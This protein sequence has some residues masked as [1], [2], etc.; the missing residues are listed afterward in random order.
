MTGDIS[1]LHTVD[2]EQRETYRLSVEASDGLQQ[3]QARLILVVQDANDNIPTFAAPSFSF[4]VYESA[5]KGV[6]VGKITA[7]DEDRGD[8]AVITY[9]LISD[10]GNE[11][12][13]L[14]PTTG[15]FTLT[16]D[17]DFETEE[18]YRFVVSGSDHG[19]CLQSTSRT[20]TITTPPSARPSTG[21]R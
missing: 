12:F 10:W 16:S 4:D 13:S 19:D 11:V 1:L 8:N 7:T 9:D 2:R 14:N 20:S 6:Q 21:W 5:G 15:I 17:L 18:H 3:S